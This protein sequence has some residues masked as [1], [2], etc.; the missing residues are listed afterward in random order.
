MLKKAALTIVALVLIGV[1]TPSVAGAQAN[2]CI[3]DLNSDGYV[4]ISDYSAFVVVVFK[5]AS[6]NPKADF[7]GDGFIDISDYSI[8]SNNFLN[9]LLNCRPTP[10]TYTNLLQNSDFESSGGWSLGTA[11]IVTS[12]AQS[13]TKSIAYTTGGNPFTQGWISVTPGQQY[14]LTGWFKWTAYSGTDW[15]YSFLRITQND[16]LEKDIKHLQEL[17]EVNKW[18]KIAV[19]FVP[20]T[21][22]VKVEG[23][24]F[25]PKAVAKL[26]FDNFAVFAKTGNQP[27]TLNP[28]ATVVSGN[29]PLN[30]TFL[31]NASDIDSA[32]TVYD[33]DF[34]DGAR[35]RTDSVTHRF[36]TPGVYKSKLTV[37]DT[38]GATSSKEVTITVN[39]ASGRE[40]TIAGSENI[41][42]SN[43]KISL[44]GSSKSNT[45]VTAVVW[46]N[47]NTFDAGTISV[48]SAT[49]VN[50]QTPEINLKPGNNEILITTT[51]SAGYT[52]TDKVKVYRQI[53]QPQISQVTFNKS[54]LVKNEKLEIQFQLATVA[55]HYMFK[56]DAQ[57]PVGVVGATGVTAEA[58]ITLPNGQVVTQPAFYFEQTAKS[59]V[60]T[61]A[62]V[63]T[64]QSNWRVRFTP[65]LTGN[66][67]VQIFAQD[68]SGS[69]Q[70]AAGSFT[71]TDSANKGFIRVAA[72]DSRYFEYDNGDLYWPIGPAEEWRTNTPGTMNLKRTWL[73]GMGI[74]STNW[75]RWKSSAEQHGNEGVKE[76]LNFLEA[77]PGSEL[78]HDLFYPEGA[79]I[80]M[81]YWLDDDFAHVLENNTNY[82]IKLRLK[83]IDLAGPREA[84]KAWGLTVKRHDW[85]GLEP[86]PANLANKPAL[87][88]HI[89]TTRDWHTVVAR[90]NTGS[91]GTSDRDLSIYLENVTAG[92]AYVDEM[93]IRKV[94]PDGTLGAELVRNPKADMHKFVEQRPA[95]YLD[96]QVEI[97]RANGV[98]NIFV[99]MDKNDWIPNHLN[100]YGR[101]VDYGDGYYQPKGTKARWLIEQWWRYI[102]ARWGY[103]T[104]VFSW[105]LNNEGPP[106]DGTGEHSQMTQDMG[107]FFKANNAHKQLVSTSFWCCWEPGFWGNKQKFPDVAYA[108]IHD[109]TNGRTNYE[110]DPV[111]WYL[112]WANEIIG[113]NVGKPVIMGESGING[114]QNFDILKQQNNGLWYHQFTWA[115]LHH[116]ALFSPLYWHTEHLRVIN[117]A[118]IAGNV[119]KFVSNLDVHKGGY[120][121]LVANISNSNIQVFGQKNTTSRKA[122]MWVN[123]KLN[124]WYARYSN[125]NV[126]AQTGQITFAMPAGSYKLEWWN[127]S[128]GS[129]SS[130]ENIST[131]AAGNLIINISNLGSDIALK[132]SQN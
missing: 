104:N 127:T 39:N 42:T 116:S 98:N 62:Y 13:G 2:A 24:M 27:P 1:L 47:V 94:M 89:Q 26:W 5:P 64:G 67:S 80:W 72:A 56:Y 111:S 44:T 22:Q 118:Q 102:A 28:T 95:G 71:V 114:Q 92:R 3:D 131:N 46:D 51:D 9:G 53:G 11:S 54:Q 85:T 23:G 100:V 52:S 57:P 43:T 103:A 99:V 78:S 25:G 41:T 21:N 121:D 29:A 79:R 61:N 86:N 109:Y 36:I 90:F 93:S 87:I 96:D 4:D 84:G 123:N 130:T 30:V 119:H 74:Y 18:H 126:P 73:G 60:R 33:W 91:T 50:W 108:D 45:N 34:G 97:S 88:P 31:S 81:T 128:T 101:F 82:Q 55:D 6:A 20:T 14:M 112:S 122:Y 37:V 75:A 40:T 49:Q 105:E 117:Q 65:S 125:Q 66:Y 48:S 58:K 10:P 59:S 12:D 17:Y 115:Q 63:L 16:G 132:I 32:I 83:T 76:H 15:G 19:P 38:E 69:T 129:V 120:K 113:D 7:N 8:F 70:V 35:G 107:A 77:Y 106:D 124:T 110:Q 68:A